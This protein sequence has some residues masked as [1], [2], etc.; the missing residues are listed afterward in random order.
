MPE[1]GL[2]TVAAADG[3]DLLAAARTDWSRPV[4]DCPGWTAAGLVGHMGAILG[5]MAKIV[6]TGEAVPRRD[7][8]VPPADQD[9]LAAWYST[10]LDRTLSVLAAG[11]AQAPAWTFSSRGDKQVGW[12]RRRVAVELAIHRWDAQHAAG[13]ER[14]L[15]PALDGNVAAA[16]IEEFLTEF[17]PGLL[18]QPGL[19]GLTGSLH[20][21][22]TDGASEWWVSLDDKER[23]VAVPGHRKA[24]TA[25]RATRSDLLLWLTNRQQPGALEISGSPEAAAR[26][27]QLRR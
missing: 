24:D 2:L 27:V 21:H 6:A 16:G 14:A 4:P 18:T 12:W 11:P 19:E 20:L 25:I 10:R 3:R 1:L 23:A 17:L 26:W 13:P 15:P 7:R 9:A 22:A 8:E 5:W